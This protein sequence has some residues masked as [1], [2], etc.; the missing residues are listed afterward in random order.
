MAEKCFKNMAAVDLLSDFY[1]RDF[2]L[3]LITDEIAQKLEEV[4]VLKKKE[5]LAAQRL[6]T[7]TH[8]IDSRNYNNNPY[9]SRI[10][11]NDK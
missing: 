6:K 1:K 7:V 4:K 11:R 9:N 5:L 10:N 2:E 8:W 3:R